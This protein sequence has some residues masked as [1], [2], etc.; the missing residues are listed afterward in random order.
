MTLEP[1]SRTRRRRHRARNALW[2]FGLALAACALAAGAALLWWP[3]P[4]VEPDAEALA[5]IVEP[6]YAGHVSE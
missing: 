6:G 5:R 1:V 3:D 2:A 4:R